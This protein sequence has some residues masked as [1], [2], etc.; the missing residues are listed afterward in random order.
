MTHVSKQAR[1]TEEAYKHFRGSVDTV[2]PRA[3]SLSS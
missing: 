3:G 1:L 2:R